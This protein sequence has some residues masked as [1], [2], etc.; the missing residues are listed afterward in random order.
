MILQQGNPLPHKL[1][2]SYITYS[3]VKTIKHEFSGA[4]DLHLIQYGYRRTF[5]F[6]QLEPLQVPLVQAPITATFTPGRTSVL[7]LVCLSWAPL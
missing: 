3:V 2:N 1:P 7:R 5:I 6:F 4:Y